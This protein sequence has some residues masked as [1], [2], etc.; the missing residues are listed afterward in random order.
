MGS[1]KKMSDKE[2]DILKRNPLTKK[3]VNCKHKKAS[4]GMCSTCN[5]VVCEGCGKVIGNQRSMSVFD[6]AA[7]LTM[8][9]CCTEKME[10]NECLERPCIWHK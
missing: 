7:S 5:A 10:C 9:S 3:Q 1:K 4:K 2:K 6:W 8:R